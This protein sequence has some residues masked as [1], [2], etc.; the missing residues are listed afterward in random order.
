M[1]ILSDNNSRFTIH[2]MCIGEIFRC[3]NEVYMRIDADTSSQAT[4]LNLTDYTK[5]EYL[6]GD[7]ECTLLHSSICI[8][9]LSPAVLPLKAFD[10]GETFA[11]RRNNPYV[12]TSNNGKTILVNLATGNVVEPYDSNKFEYYRCNVVIRFGNYLEGQ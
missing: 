9:N 10:I 12:M 8:R 1:I 3:V 6:N 4:C 11:D 7:F 2:S 5:V